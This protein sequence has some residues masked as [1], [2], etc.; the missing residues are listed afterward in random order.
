MTQERL[1]QTLTSILL[2]ADF[3]VSERCGMRPRSFDI[4]GARGTTVLVIKVAPHIDSVSEENA[5]DLALISRYIKGAPM[6]IGEKARDSELERGAVYLRYGIVAM[7]VMTLYD[8]LVEDAPPL[9]YAQPGGLYV[10]INGALL[11]DLREERQMSLGDLAGAL[12]VSR[13]TISKY[14]GGMGMTLDIAIRLEE[15]FDAAIV[16]AI[17][18]LENQQH[19]AHHHEDVTPQNAPADLERIGMELHGIRRAPFEALAVYEEETILTGYGPA[20]KVMRRAALIG[21]ISDITNSRAVCVIKDYNKRKKVGK[22]LVI[23]ER[24]LSGL[25]SGSDLIDLIDD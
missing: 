7:N 20:Q 13:R 17:E 6:I 10:N 23:G 4:I 22:T 14:E 3:K 24:H 18:L 11:R 16:E 8:Y 2:M 15:I 25:E 5:R 19:L 9:V 1:L 21:N 12:G